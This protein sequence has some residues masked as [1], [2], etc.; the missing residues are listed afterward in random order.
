MTKD[1]WPLDVRLEILRARA[2]VVAMVPAE[3]ITGVI[4]TDARQAVDQVRGRLYGFDVVLAPPSAPWPDT[5]AM[6]S[7]RRRG[8]I[9][10]RV[11]DLTRFF[12]ATN[13]KAIAFRSSWQAT[14]AGVRMRTIPIADN[15]EMFRIAARNDRTDNIA[16]TDIRRLDPDELMAALMDAIFLVDIDIK[17]A[18]RD[19]P[20]RRK[21]V[22]EPMRWVT[23]ALPAV[24]RPVSRKR[25]VMQVSIGD[26]EP[27]PRRRKVT[28]V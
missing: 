12:E 21:S 17:S 22:A 24:K 23:N 2:D 8:E 15:I 16:E 28:P 19:N 13:W 20:Y 4:Y 26:G 1:H 25:K 6:A 5:S 7:T 10:E 11:A 18:M 14:V 9:A 3:T 27:A